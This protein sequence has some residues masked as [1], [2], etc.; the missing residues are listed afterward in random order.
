MSTKEYSKEI[1]E[2]ILNDETGDYIFKAQV[3][4]AM[5]PLGW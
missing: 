4:A 5:R 2:T 1:F 3:L